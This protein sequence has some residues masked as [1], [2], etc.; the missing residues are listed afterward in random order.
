[1]QDL[2]QSFPTKLRHSATCDNPYTILRYISNH[3]Y[4]QAM[5]G[6]ASSA[7]CLSG[8]LLSRRA[9][10]HPR[11]TERDS[12]RLQHR[13]E[14]AILRSLPVGGI[15]PLGQTTIPLPASPHCSGPSV[16]I[17]P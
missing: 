2:D 6:L 4:V 12:C 13:I 15:V 10:L 14:V 9:P 17:A 7:A 8:N 16:Q 3:I 1:M 5:N 11:G